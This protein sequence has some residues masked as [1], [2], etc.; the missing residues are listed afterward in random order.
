MAKKSEATEQTGG[1][2]AAKPRIFKASLRADG[3]V[4]K[5]SEINETEAVGERQTQR[6]VVVCGNDPDA[7]NELAK[8]IEHA[9]SGSYVRHGTHRPNGLNHFQPLARPPAGHTFYETKNSRARR[10]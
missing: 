1:Q 5:G 2:P 8:R 4:V 9:A 10:K 7:N 6:E 3:S